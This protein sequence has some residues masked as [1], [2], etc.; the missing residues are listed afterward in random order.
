MGFFWKL[1]IL[2]HYKDTNGEH[3]ASVDQMASVAVKIIRRRPIVANTK[4]GREVKYWAKGFGFSK[5]NFVVF[6]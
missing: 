6:F 3:L 2:N 4:L 1:P 5:K